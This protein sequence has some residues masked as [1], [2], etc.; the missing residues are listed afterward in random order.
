MGRYTQQANNEITEQE[1]DNRESPQLLAIDFDALGRPDIQP[2]DE[3]ELT[4]LKKEVIM[5]LTADNTGITGGGT[6]S[7]ASDGC[8][9]RHVRNAEQGES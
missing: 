8:E 3:G 5:K 4:A 6:T 9:E 2:I 7:G 1:D